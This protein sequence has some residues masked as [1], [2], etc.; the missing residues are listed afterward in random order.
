MLPHRETLDVVAGV[1]NPD[2]EEIWWATANNGG[3]QLDTA[4]EKLDWP[5]L[6]LRGR[7]F[8]DLVLSVDESLLFVSNQ[9]LIRVDGENRQVTSLEDLGEVFA[10]ATAVDL[11]PWVATDQGVATFRRDR[12]SFLTTADGLP[13]NTIIGILLQEDGSLWVLSETAVSHIRP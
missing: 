1:P 4:T 11:R 12:W 2:G 10:V 13:S 6:H 8:K 5:I 9:Q 3:I 7:K